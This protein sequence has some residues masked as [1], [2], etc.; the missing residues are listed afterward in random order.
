MLKIGY[1][2]FPADTKITPEYST[3]H[4]YYAKKEQEIHIDKIRF[5]INY[6]SP[7]CF[8]TSTTII[9]ASYKNFL[10]FKRNNLELETV[11]LLHKTKRYFQFQQHSLLPHVVTGQKSHCSPRRT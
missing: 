11:I 9:R 6:Y 3:K 5:I 1:Q 4:L 2:K 7:T 10:G 8:G